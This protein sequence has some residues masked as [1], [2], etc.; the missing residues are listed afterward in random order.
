M[1]IGGTAI[2]LELTYGSRDTKKNKPVKIPQTEL[3]VSEDIVIGISQGFMQ[4]SYNMFG[5]TGAGNIAARMFE[6]EDWLDLD[7]Q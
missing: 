7:W 4:W 2:Y 5:G 1:L 3:N 6:T